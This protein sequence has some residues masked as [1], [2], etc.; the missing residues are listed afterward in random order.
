MNP[1][2]AKGILAKLVDL[3]PLHLAPGRGL[4]TRERPET[5]V[6]SALAAK[7]GGFYGVTTSN[8]KGIPAVAFGPCRIEPAHPGDEFID[9]REPADGARAFPPSPAFACALSA[10]GRAKGAQ[11]RAYEAQ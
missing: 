10:N 4:R 7:E 11:Q 8:R 9:E 2:P 6:R 1:K 3:P 5:C